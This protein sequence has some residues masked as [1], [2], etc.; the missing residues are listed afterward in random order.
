MNHN[1][2]D[3]VVECTGHVYGDDCPGVVNT[4]YGRSEGHCN[5]VTSPYG[6]FNTKCVDEPNQLLS[7]ND[8]PFLNPGLHE[9]REGDPS[10]NRC[11]EVEEGTDQIEDVQGRLKT[12]LSFWE[13]ELEPTPW[14]IRKGYKLPLHPVP[15]QF[16]KPNQQSALTNVEFV[17]E[18]LSELEHNQCIK[19]VDHQP[20]VCIPLSVV[21]NGRG[22]FRLVINLRYLNQFLWQDKF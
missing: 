22:R 13:K 5:V 8:R 14:I 7:E 20:H 21:D 2:V 16:C 19:Q 3:G 6:V 17:N 15:N 9:G 10:L 18:A 1:G 12:C 11:W 4:V